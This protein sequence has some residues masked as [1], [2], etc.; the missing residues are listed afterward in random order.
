M[1]LKIYKFTWISFINIPGSQVNRKL[2][3]DSANPGP[4][5][6]NYTLLI[7]CSLEENL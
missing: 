1:F 7:T 5:K 6:K 2:V 3:I 4:W